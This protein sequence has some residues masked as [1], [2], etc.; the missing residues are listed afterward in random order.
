LIDFGPKNRYSGA[1]APE[2]HDREDL[3]NLHLSEKTGRWIL[4]WYDEH[5]AR[6]N[7]SFATLK[8]AEAFQKQKRAELE[9]HRGGRFP[10]AEQSALRTDTGVSRT[11]ALQR[12]PIL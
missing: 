4:N 12:L 10:A 2:A 3:E 5:G 1:H 8:E 6:R 11:A 7:P 9:R